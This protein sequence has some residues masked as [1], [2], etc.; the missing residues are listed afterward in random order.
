[1][2]DKPTDVPLCADK[3]GS[4]RSAPR[5]APEPLDLFRSNTLFPPRCAPRAEAEQP[6]AYGGRPLAMRLRVYP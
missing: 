1:M 5:P 4:G 3:S 6:A 2:F